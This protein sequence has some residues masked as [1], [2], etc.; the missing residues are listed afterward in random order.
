MDILSFILNIVKK[1]FK[2]YEKK[3][4][5]QVTEIVEKKE[6]RLVQKTEEVKKAVEENREE[7]IKEVISLNDL[8]TASGAYPQRNKDP[9]LTKEVLQNLEILKNKVNL[10]LHKKGIKKATVSSGFRPSAVNA[11]IANAATL[12]SHITG[13]ACDIL[14]DKGQSLAR[15]I[16]SVFLEEVGLYMEHPDHTIGKNTNWCHL[17]TRRTRSGNRIFKP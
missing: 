7:I 11:N 6:E 17:Q 14:D 12:S 3:E 15:S 10:V 2:E 8:I 16:D 9:G 1:L 4:S 5:A 13:E